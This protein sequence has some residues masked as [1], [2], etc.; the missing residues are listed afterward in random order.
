MRRFWFGLAKSRLVQGHPAFST[1]KTPER[2]P[3]AMFQTPQPTPR[4]FQRDSSYSGSSLVKN[5]PPLLAAKHHRK[6]ISATT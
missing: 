2:L 3:P 6:N 4:W 5:A 1:L